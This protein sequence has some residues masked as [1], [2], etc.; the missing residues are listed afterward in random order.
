M[1]MRAYIQEWRAE[2]GGA[3]EEEDEYEYGVVFQLISG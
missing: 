3:G 2:R 1:Y